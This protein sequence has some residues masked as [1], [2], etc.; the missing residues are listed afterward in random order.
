[1]ITCYPA[2]S[3]TRAPSPAGQETVYIYNFEGDNMKY[4]RIAVLSVG[5]GPEQVLPDAPADGA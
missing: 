4:L 2:G 5:K 3:G 1:M